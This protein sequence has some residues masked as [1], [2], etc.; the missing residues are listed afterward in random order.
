MI[1][2]NNDIVVSPFVIIVSEV[3]LEKADEQIVDTDMTQLNLL[4]VKLEEIGIQCGSCKT[5]Q[6]NGLLCPMV[7]TNHCSSIIMILF[8]VKVEISSH[9]VYETVDSDYVLF[10]TGQT[11]K[12]DYIIERKHVSNRSKVS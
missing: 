6:T 1:I 5:G 9:F 8:L 11:A 4:R 10:V 7:C 12:I 3:Y 2:C